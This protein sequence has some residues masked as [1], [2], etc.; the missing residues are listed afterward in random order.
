MGEDF[1]RYVN[2]A[3]THWEVNL[4]ASY[5]TEYWQLHNDR[6]QNGA[7]KSELASSK[8]RFYMK[9]RLAGLPAEILPCEIVIVVRDAIMN[10]FMNI[11]YSILPR[12]GTNDSP[13]T[14]PNQ[15][16]LTRTPAL[17]PGRTAPCTPPRGPA[18]T[19][20]AAARSRRCMTFDAP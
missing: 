20:P 15:R 9:K 13:M 7:F 14:N 3:A 10:S 5:G 8:S 2:E 16:I 11:Q 1:L 6:R 19:K 18:C 17:P 12:L 4:G